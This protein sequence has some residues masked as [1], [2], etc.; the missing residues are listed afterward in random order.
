MEDW[1]A[2]TASQLQTQHSTL[3]TTAT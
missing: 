2:F 3:T 1:P